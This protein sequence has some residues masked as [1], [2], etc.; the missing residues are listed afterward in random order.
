MDNEFIV[1]DSYL[2]IESSHTIR[3]IKLLEVL[4]FLIKNDYTYIT[5]Q[6]GKELI[7]STSLSGLI[8]ILPNWFYRINKSAIINMHH[9]EKCEFSYRNSYIKMIDS[10]QFS[11]SR[12]KYTLFKT[13]YKEFLILDRPFTDKNNPFTDCLE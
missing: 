8:Q 2:I 11:I 12:R 5:L 7:I 1:K 13:I 9:C 3:K 10:A 6:C 4:Y